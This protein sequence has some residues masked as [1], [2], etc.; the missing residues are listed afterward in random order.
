MVKA[1]RYIVVQWLKDVFDIAC[2]GEK[3]PHEWREAIIVPIY[4]KKGS[5]DECGNYRGIS[6]LSVVGKIYARVVC[7]SLRVLIDAVL[8]DEQGGFRARRGC[9][10]QIFAVRQVIEKVI[11]KDKVVYAAFVDLEKAYDS[12][13]RSKLW[14]ALK[15][16]VQGQ[17][18][19]AVQSFYEEGWARVRVAGKESSSFQVRKGVRQGCPLSPWLF[20]IFIDRIVSEARN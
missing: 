10:N 3:I 14:V 11:E 1:G 4:Y 8:M 6:L 5:R 17:L 15:D 19:A 2:K 16:G 7:D 13:S 12:V 20:N 18:L 9:V